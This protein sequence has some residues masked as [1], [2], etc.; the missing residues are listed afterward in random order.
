MFLGRALGGKRDVS[1]AM[2]LEID[3]EIKRLVTENHE[4]AKRMLTEQIVSLK[5]LAV[6]LLEKEVLDAS[7]ID[8][9]ILE[10]SS[11]TIPA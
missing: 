8:E 5:V 4:R 7:E 9:I 1:D 11:Q 3:L 2:A 10:S 6:A